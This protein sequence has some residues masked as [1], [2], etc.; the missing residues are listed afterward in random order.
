MDG[1]LSCAGFDLVKRHPFA[2]RRHRPPKFHSLGAIKRFRLPG[3]ILDEYPPGGQK[4]TLGYR[5][6]FAE[7]VF[8]GPDGGE[9]PRRAVL[10]PM[11]GSDHRQ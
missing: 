8:A 2:A 10:P 6:D 3:A 9:G 7:A 1:G 5:S 4:E 11:I